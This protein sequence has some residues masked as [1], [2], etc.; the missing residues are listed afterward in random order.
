[1]SKGPITIGRNVWVGDNVVI[2]GNVKIGDGVIVAAGSVIIKDVPSYSL[3][4][5]VPAVIKKSLVV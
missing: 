2:L 3:V 1:M 5:G 4:A